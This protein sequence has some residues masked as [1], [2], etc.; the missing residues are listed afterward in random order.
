[1]EYFMGM[2]WD[3]MGDLIHIIQHNYSIPSELLIITIDL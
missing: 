3:I 1:M 2:K